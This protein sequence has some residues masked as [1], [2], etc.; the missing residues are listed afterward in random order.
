MLKRRGEF[1]PAAPYAEMRTFS[2]ATPEATPEGYQATAR[3]AVVV[4]QMKPF[5]V[6]ALE[7]KGWVQAQQGEGDI[8]IACAAGRREAE[9]HRRLPWRI[10]NVTGEAFEDRDF[11][12]GG[13]V[14]DAFDRSGGQIWHGAARTEIDLSR[15]SVDRVRKAVNAALTR[16]PAHP[17][18]N[19]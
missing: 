16:F 13:I 8:T 9:T 3:S 6:A 7:A 19:P 18:A 17:R 14:I 5:I 12:E 2:F 11:V 4:E 1:V 10:T 15:P